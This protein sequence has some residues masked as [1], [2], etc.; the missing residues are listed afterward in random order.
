MSMFVF[1]WCGRNEDVGVGIWWSLWA[2][3]CSCSW[4]SGST[5]SLDIDVAVHVLVVVVASVERDVLGSRAEGMFE[6]AHAWP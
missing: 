6:K 1:G 2:Q 3:W 4:M 5:L